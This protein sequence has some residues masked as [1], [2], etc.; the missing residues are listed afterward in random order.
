[1]L[2]RKLDSKE[3]NNSLKNLKMD[4]KVTTINDLPVVLIKYIG[5][6]FDLDSLL[7]FSS[8]NQKLK[9]LFLE[10]RKGYSY[11]N[12]IGFI[13]EYECRDKKN[14]FKQVIIN[15]NYSNLK[16]KY[17]ET[18]LHFACWNKNVSMEMIKYYVENKCEI[19]EKNMYNNNSFHLICSN[20]NA[21]VDIIKFFL[22]SK[23]DINSKGFLHSTPLQ[24]ASRNTTLKDYLKQI[25]N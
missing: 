4:E 1:M 18:P 22:E 15:K 19:S 21:S 13:K 14:F 2:K 16:S 17:G 5:T 24:H 3:E 23:G 6:F 10:F 8:T 25:F 12:V 20:E 7:N 9:S 11:L